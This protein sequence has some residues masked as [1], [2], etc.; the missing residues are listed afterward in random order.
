[1]KRKVRFIMRSVTTHEW[2]VGGHLGI[3]ATFVVNAALVAS[4]CEHRAWSFSLHP[5]INAEYE[6]GQATNTVFQIFVCDPTLI[7]V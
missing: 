7:F 6:A 5:S 3:M 4:Q 2:F 1:M